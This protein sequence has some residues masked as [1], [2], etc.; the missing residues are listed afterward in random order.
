MRTF[1][2]K[3]LFSYVSVALWLEQSSQ[4]PW[5]EFKV[6]KDSPLKIFMEHA[7]VEIPGR[8]WYLCLS[9]EPFL[10]ILNP[11]LYCDTYM[12]KIFVQY[13]SPLVPRCRPE[14]GE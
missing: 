14:T 4:N 10:K 8:T 7:S 6:V 11:P 2:C 1:I 3:N 9:L 5:S 12:N 13:Y